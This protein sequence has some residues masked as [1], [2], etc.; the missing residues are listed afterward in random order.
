MNAYDT[1]YLKKFDGISL[2]KAI[3]VSATNRLAYLINSDWI[4]S[5]HW[6]KE[7]NEWLA[8]VKKSL[9]SEMKYA[10]DRLDQLDEAK[11]IIAEIEGE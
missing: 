10:I 8:A 11:K 4:H 9:E 5:S 7:H 3:K 2:G 1:R 6:P